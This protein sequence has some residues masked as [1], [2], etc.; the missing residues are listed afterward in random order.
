MVSWGGSGRWAWEGLGRAMRKLS[1]VL[2]MLIIFFVKIVFQ[3]YIYVITYETAYFK[4]VFMVCQL[5]LNKL[6]KN[7]GEPRGTWWLSGLSV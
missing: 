6:F 1:W 3:V 2:R 7:K 4:Y 5:H